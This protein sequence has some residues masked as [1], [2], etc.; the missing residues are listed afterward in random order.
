MKSSVFIL[1]AHGSRDP[2]WLSHFDSLL[3]RMRS[4]LPQF[5]IHLCYLEI[6][7]PSLDSLVE[8]LVG[9]GASSF[10]IW[11]LFLASGGH[12]D[13]DIP[14]QIKELESTYKQCSF[15]VWTPLG[16][17]PAVLDVMISEINAKM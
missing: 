9:E 4:S 8:A 6:A 12:V 17:H 15:D 5:A 1:M 16:E 3:E 2:K 11:P 7:D 10:T 13:R 14:L